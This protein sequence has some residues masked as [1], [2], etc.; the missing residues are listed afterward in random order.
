MF[1]NKINRSTITCNFSHQTRSMFPPPRYH[2]PRWRSGE[3]G[4]GIPKIAWAIARLLDT[5]SAQAEWRGAP[6]R[7]RSQR[8]PHPRQ[9][10][11]YYYGNQRREGQW[12]RRPSSAR[13][14]DWSPRMLP[15]RGPPVAAIRA[16]RRYQRDEW[17][18]R[19]PRGTI[20]RGP[21][22]GG[23]ARSA[24]DPQRKPR[25]GLCGG[26]G[27]SAKDP[28]TPPK[29]SREKTN[30]GNPR[31]EAQ[32]KRPTVITVGKNGQ[33]RMWGWL[34]RSTAWRVGS[35]W[36]GMK[37]NVDVFLEKDGKRKKVQVS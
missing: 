4:S 18:T 9:W 27:R 8:T 15:R 23:P 5:G 37:G 32:D 12:P 25:G 33:E 16:P 11:P 24:G 35:F 13:P 21:L 29:T 31:K 7:D 1:K 20:P 19:L 28:Q 14:W 36:D 10:L 2:A 3:R 30:G 34:S 26:P 22:R 6:P 17:E